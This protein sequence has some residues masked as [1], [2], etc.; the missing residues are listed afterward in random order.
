MITIK[1]SGSFKNTETFLN[2]MKNREQF[3]ILEKYGP[4]G[5]RALSDA[6]PVDSSLTSKSW[7]YEVISK[8]GFY[9]IE[10]RNTHIENGVPI[11]II[12]QYGHGTGS[13]GFVQGRDYINPAMRPI[14]DK[15]V[16]DMW[17]VVT[18]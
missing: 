9:S 1:V 17:K 15:M 3:R 6:T 11:A 4:I 7:T 5:V 10:W 18:K 16:N 12:L 14:F 2:R 13:G 8:A